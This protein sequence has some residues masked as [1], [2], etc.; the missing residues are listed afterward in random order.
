MRI[1][2]ENTIAVVIDIQERLHPVI[3][4]NDELEKNSLILINGLKALGVPMLVTQ[5]YTK[6]LG[7]TIP[8]VAEALGSFEPIE[9]VAFSC[10][11]EAKFAEA[12]AG[13]GRKNVIIFGEETHVCVLQTVIDL[14]AAGYQPVVVEDCVSSRKLSDKHTAIQRIK[15]EGAIVTSYESILFELTRFAGTDTFKVISKLVK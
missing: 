4:G 5:Q 9:K 6:A 10:F 12:L 7:A 2:K 3:S 13:S 1:L 15:N 11:D 14:V 8:S